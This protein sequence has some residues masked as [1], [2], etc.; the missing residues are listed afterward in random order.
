MNILNFSLILANAAILAVAA[1]DVSTSNATAT[2]ESLT[3]Q[4]QTNTGQVSTASTE[5]S[6]STNAA[7]TSN[8]F[9]NM[10]KWNLF[11]KSSTNSGPT[12]DNNA[13]TLSSSTADSS[14]MSQISGKATEMW[15]SATGAIP[16]IPNLG[17]K[18]TI[19]YIGSQANSLT[20]KSTKGKESSKLE[21]I[22]ACSATASKD[23]F[24]KAIKGYVTDSKVEN[25]SNQASGEDAMKDTNLSPYDLALKKLNILFNC[26]K[27]NEL[28][29]QLKE[30]ELYED[31]SKE[32]PAIIQEALKQKLKQFPFGSLQTDYDRA[33]QKCVESINNADHQEICTNAPCSDN[34]IESIETNIKKRPFCSHHFL[35]KSIAKVAEVVKKDVSEKRELD[36]NF[37]VSRPTLLKLIINFANTLPSL[38]ISTLGY[39][40]QNLLEKTCLKCRINLQKLLKVSDFDVPS[41]EDLFKESAKKEE[42]STGDVGET[43][44]PVEVTSTDTT[45]TSSASSTDSKTV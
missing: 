45:Q 12:T 28:L 11:S 14:T 27:S 31:G 2:N 20:S 33:L 10:P 22:M 6:S 18:S 17:I 9:S 35:E 44:V 13:S 30:E 21:R 29:A 25:K 1:S 38:Q 42:K 26:T 7:K 39:L 23:E 36:K 24:L 43:T 19:G 37:I 15:N 32:I 41:Y 40:N 34:D 4:S 3:T 5:N 8:L 16:P